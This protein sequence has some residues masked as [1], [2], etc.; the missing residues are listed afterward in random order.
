MFARL[1]NNIGLRSLVNALGLCLLLSFA[2][3]WAPP[4]LMAWLPYTDLSWHNLGPLGF[5]LIFLLFTVGSAFAF[6]EWQNDQHV[7]AGNYYYFLYFFLGA[8]LLYVYWSF[9][10]YLLSLPL[11]LLLI[12]IARRVTLPKIDLSRLNFLAAFLV[13]LLSFFESEAV[14]LLSIPLLLSLFFGG[15]S[16]Q[17]FGA[18]LLGYGATLYF[19]LAL[20]FFFD[21]TLIDQ[22]LGQW[23]ELTWQMIDWPA[24]QLFGLGALTLHV[25]ISLLV[26]YSQS[27]RYNNE[28]KASLGFWLL[29]LLLGIAAVLILE[30]KGLWLSLCLFPYAFFTARALQSLE[31]HWLKDALALTPILITLFFV[32]S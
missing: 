3:W 4:H 13:G 12:S 28:Q 20:D 10:A 19:A 1:F 30:H 32:F 25:L 24:Q 23:S 21:W 11:L 22:S 14:Y 15:L 29:L 6:N 26:A 9:S 16:L 2:F 8:N 7:F 27:A 18:L 5:Y 31:N 17:S